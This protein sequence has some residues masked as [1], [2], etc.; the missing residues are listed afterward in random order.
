MSFYGVVEEM[1][2]AWHEYLNNL[3]LLEQIDRFFNPSR[4]SCSTFWFDDLWWHIFLVCVFGAVFCG[5]LLML[6]F[7]EY[8]D[9][10]VYISV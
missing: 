10:K 9:R 6:L 5:V 3:T 2:Q 4:Y 8:D 7:R 1:S